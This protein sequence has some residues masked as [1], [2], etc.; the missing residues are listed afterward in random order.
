MDH[1]ALKSNL[2][3]DSL[4]IIQDSTS[5]WQQESSQMC[6]VYRHCLLCIAAGSASGS[7]KGL[8]NNRDPTQLIAS[9][10]TEMARPDHTQQVFNLIDLDF[11]K[12][13]VVRSPLN[14]RAWVLQERLLAPRILRFEKD[15]LYW[16]CSMSLN[17]ESFPKGFPGRLPLVGKNDETSDIEVRKLLHMGPEPSMDG[18]GTQQ[19]L[20]GL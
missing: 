10:I 6:D 4:C 12:N 5:D 7:T 1:E 20:Y 19:Y 2:L 3:L 17:C 9:C 8:F 13:R 11:W 16:E 18:A 15:Q 14:Q